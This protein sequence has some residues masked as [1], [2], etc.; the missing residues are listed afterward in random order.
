MK[1]ENTIEMATTK[2]LL[3][4]LIVSGRE[5]H[6]HVPSNYVRPANDRP[7]LDE[8]HSFDG[9]IPLIDLNGLHGLDRS[10][11]I[12]QSAL[13]CQNYGFFQVILS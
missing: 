9:S 6:F 13:A 4:D 5:N 2:P 7:N 10:H 8:V 1:G 11:I 12:N 3:S